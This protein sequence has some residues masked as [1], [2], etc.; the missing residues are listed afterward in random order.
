MVV[1]CLPC[2]LVKFMQN[3]LVGTS[4]VAQRIK[5]LPT[6]RETWVWS[7]DREDL[8]KKE[9][10]THFSILAWRIPRM[11]EP[12]RLQSTGSQRVGHYWATSLTHSCKVQTSEQGINRLPSVFSWTFHTYLWKNQN[13]KTKQNKNPTLRESDF[14]LIFQAKEKGGVILLMRRQSLKWGLFLKETCL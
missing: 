2:I 13:S 3:S 12:G 14:S 5:R 9:M 7:M 8:V 6:M 11:E 4:L 10:A 1:K